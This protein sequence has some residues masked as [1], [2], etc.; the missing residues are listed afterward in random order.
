MG[1]MVTMNLYIRQCGPRE[2]CLKT[3]SISVPNGRYLTSITCC[4]TDNCTPPE[5]NLPEVSIAKNG[6]KC[7]ACFVPN[8]KSCD[9]VTSMDCIGNETI[10]IT[11]ITNLK[12]PVP[13][14]QVARG[15]ATKGLCDPVHQVWNINKSVVDLENICA[16]CGHRLQENIL[17]LIFSISVFWKLLG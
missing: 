9:K 12:G 6:M 10:C 17:A 5:P 4:D 7:P 16:N 13:S 14:S 8:A 15:C 1:E 3:G 11:Q 2:L